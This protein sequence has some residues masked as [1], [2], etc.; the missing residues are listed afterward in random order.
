MPSLVLSG[1]GASIEYVLLP[2]GDE[3]VHANSKWK[4]CDVSHYYM[5]RLLRGERY[6]VNVD[7]SLD[8]PTEEDIAP[9]V[10]CYGEYTNKSGCCFIESFL[11][12]LPFYGPEGF[13]ALRA[14]AFA[15]NKENGLE[16]YFTIK[17]GFV[18]IEN[19]NSKPTGDY[20]VKVF[21]RHIAG[22]NPHKFDEHWVGVRGVDVYDCRFPGRVLKTSNFRFVGASGPGKDTKETVFR[23]TELYAHPGADKGVIAASFSTLVKDLGYGDKEPTRLAAYNR[24]MGSLHQLAGYYTPAIPDLEDEKLPDPQSG[25]PPVRVIPVLGGAETSRPSAPP[26]STAAPA[27]QPLLAPSSGGAG[28]GGRPPFKPVVGTMPGGGAPPS[29]PPFNPLVVPGPAS[30]GGNASASAAIRRPTLAQDVP[31]VR[32]VTPY[33]FKMPAIKRPG[34]GA[35][36][37]MILGLTL[38]PYAINF[39]VDKVKE[40]R[41]G[42]AQDGEDPGDPI[43]AP[44]FDGEHLEYGA[45]EFEDGSTFNEALDYADV[46]TWNAVRILPGSH[47]RPVTDRYLHGPELYHTFVDLGTVSTV[48]M[49]ALSEALSGECGEGCSRVSRE[50]ISQVVDGLYLF[51]ANYFASED[52]S[53]RRF[54]LR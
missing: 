47:L 12:T 54:E 17:D 50:K 34:L 25:V 8:P 28:S 21:S 32:N 30:P 52:N 26:Q 36:V 49:A 53:K 11:Y 13:L 6:T 20:W 38:A 2:M 18:R 39:I 35:N 45:V 48:F 27:L 15:A 22:Q 42:R 1:F 33:R 31:L 41:E 37:L 10:K 46:T 23:T 51:F 24:P 44:T 29:I 40:Y 14:A 19:S 9:V 43:V 5:L 4:L 16:H 3:L 7:L